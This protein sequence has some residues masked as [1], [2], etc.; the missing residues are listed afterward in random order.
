ML[1]KLNEFFFKYTDIIFL[2]LLII[3]ELLNVVVSSDF[4][5]FMSNIAGFSVGIATGMW[6]LIFIEKRFKNRQE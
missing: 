3:M 1:Y 4:G 2:S 5:Y 6:I